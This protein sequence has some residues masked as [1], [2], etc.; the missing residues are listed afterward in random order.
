MAGIGRDVSSTNR[1]FDL[2]TV[3]AFQG[4]ACSRAGFLQVVCEMGEVP[5]ANRLKAELRTRAI[6]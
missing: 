2:T 5:A 6:I 4:S 1:L 3:E